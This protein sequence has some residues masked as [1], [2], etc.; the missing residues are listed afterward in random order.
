MKLETAFIA[1][2]VK[3]HSMENHLACVPTLSEWAHT[4]PFYSYINS[5]EGSEVLKRYLKRFRSKRAMKFVV[6]TQPEIRAIRTSAHIRPT[7]RPITL[8]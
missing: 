1:T 6:A 8:R 2:S 5:I 7:A 4:L 3:G